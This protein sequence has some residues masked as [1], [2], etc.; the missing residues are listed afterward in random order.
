MSYIRSYLPNRV[1]DILGYYY[2]MSM[3]TIQPY[4]SSKYHVIHII[5]NIYLG[6]LSSAIRIDDLKRDKIT[7]IISIM[8]GSYSEYPDDFTYKHIH[9][10]D[11]PWLSIDK[12]FD[13]CIKFIVS[14]HSED[15]NVLVHCMC[16]ISRSVTIILAYMIKKYNY[17]YDDA[18]KFIKDKKKSINP[19][20]GFMRQLKKYEKLVTL[21]NS[22]QASQPV[23]QTVQPMIQVSQ[24]VFPSL[25]PLRSQQS[26]QSLQSPQ[27]QQLLQSVLNA[28]MDNSVEIAPLSDYSTGEDSQHVEH[29][30]CT[31]K[32]STECMC[33]FCTQ[34][35]NILPNILSKSIQETPSTPFKSFS[36]AI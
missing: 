28:H 27:S 13:D 36:G 14:A 34:L 11:D 1:G 24:L 26:L 19:N 16:G 10:N 15:G 2:G 3:Q 9:I 18:L 35:S 8:N 4:I 30:E 29:I 25:Q 32:I 6:D 5:D 17:T 22:K 33:K 12:Y 21:V 7:H 31:R 23:L 20:D